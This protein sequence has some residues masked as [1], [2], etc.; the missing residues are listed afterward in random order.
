MKTRNGINILRISTLTKG[1]IKRSE[2]CNRKRC[3]Y[4]IFNSVFWRH[5]IPWGDHS[6]RWFDISSNQ[7]LVI[8]T[9]S[10]LCLQGY[11]RQHGGSVVTTNASQQEA[12]GLNPVR[13][14]LCQN[15][16]F[17]PHGCVGPRDPVSTF[18]KHAILAQDTLPKRDFTLKIF[19]LYLNKHY[20]TNNYLNCL[21][22]SLTTKEC[23]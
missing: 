12:W 4:F 20:Q 2:L 5:L 8:Q 1:I 10:F 14:S 6:C 9:G 16:M 3:L 22:F 23:K 18:I 13:T 17:F 7:D 21:T 11:N 15:C 19:T